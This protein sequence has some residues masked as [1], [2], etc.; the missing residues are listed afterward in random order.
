MSHVI[1]NESNRNIKAL[2]RQALRGNWGKSIEIMILYFCITSL[3]MIIVQSLTVNENILTLFMCISY[4]VMGPAKLGMSMFFIRMFRGEKTVP[5]TLLEGFHYT[6]N[7]LGLYLNIIVREVLLT[8]LFIIPGIVAMIR[9]SQAF[10]I[11]ADN[12]EKTPAQCIAESSSM[13][14]GNKDKYVRLLL[15][16]AGWYILASVPRFIVELMLA[17]ISTFD[18]EMYRRIVD[19]ALLGPATV[20]GVFAGALLIFVNIYLNASECCFYDMLTENIVIRRQE[21]EAEMFPGQ[22]VIDVDPEVWTAESE[23]KDSID[24]QECLEDET[25]DTDE[26]Y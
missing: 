21:K 11:L 10:F 15:S 13:M 14:F 8:L 16:F 25:D 23:L 12:P 17:G 2:G 22:T 7:A 5:K 3:P 1:I 6:K 20:W 26:N 9:Y 18:I 19:V 24:Q 4:I